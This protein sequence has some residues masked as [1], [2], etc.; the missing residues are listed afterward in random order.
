ME[1]LPQSHGLDE[2]QVGRSSGEDT[3]TLGT[4][5]RAA[6][7]VRDASAEDRNAAS[8]GSRATAEAS[9]LRP[10]NEIRDNGTHKNE[11]KGDEAEQGA[12][13]SVE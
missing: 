4:E 7:A 5:A 12:Q 13:H 9:L 8:E 1:L 6:N 3:T 2:L 11:T 10:G